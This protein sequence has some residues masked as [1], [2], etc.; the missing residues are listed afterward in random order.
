MLC[1]EIKRK[2]LVSMVQEM[3]KTDNLD[4]RQVWKA[5]YEEFDKL[6]FTDLYTLHKVTFPGKDKLDILIDMESETK[7]FSN[8]CNIV[9]KVYKEWNNEK[10]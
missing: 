1:I 2:K 9:E 4:Y 6:H 8:F 3:C 7:G 5:L 10:L